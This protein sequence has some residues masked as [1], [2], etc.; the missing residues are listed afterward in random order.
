MQIAFAEPPIGRE[1]RGR[2]YVVRYMRERE[3]AFPCSHIANHHPP[4]HITYSREEEGLALQAA[5]LCMYY[6]LPMYS[7]SQTLS[8]LRI[9]PM[10]CSSGQRSRKGYLPASRFALGYTSMGKAKRDDASRVDLDRSLEAKSFNN[11]PLAKSL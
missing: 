1:I 5:I 9:L 3:T 4:P 8:Q 2:P 7:Y 11:A 6:V 10:M